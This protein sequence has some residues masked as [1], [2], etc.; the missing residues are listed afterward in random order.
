M[1]RKY[2]NWCCMCKQDA[3]LVAYFLSQCLVVW[4]L[5]LSNLL[6]FR[7]ACMFPEGVVELL[8]CWRGLKVRNQKEKDW[9]LILLSLTWLLGERYPSGDTI[10]IA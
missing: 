1:G 7:F 6:G 10:M 3:I 5:W 9:V 8:H 2:W 4:E